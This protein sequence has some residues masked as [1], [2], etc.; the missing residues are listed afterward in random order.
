MKTRIDK[1]EIACVD[2]TGELEGPWALLDA[3][4]RIESIGTHR[5]DLRHGEFVW[6]TDGVRTQALPYCAGVPHGSLFRWTSTSASPVQ[7]GTLLDG[8]QHGAWR[9][10]HDNGQLAR[11]EH[12]RH[13][14]HHGVFA[15]WD[16]QGRLLGLFVLVDGN[17]PWRHWADN[18]VVLTE[19]QLR[20]GK[21]VGRWI[22]R[23]QFGDVLEETDHGN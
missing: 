6:Y 19:G 4:G 2:S 7:Q 16:D 3:Q 15:Q 14:L 8:E 12:Y 20:R 13:G 5:D 17:G 21:P 18:G 11:L 22:A 1:T 23:T 10:W 9:T